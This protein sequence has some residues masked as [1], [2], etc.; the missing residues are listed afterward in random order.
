MIQFK[1]RELCVMSTRKE[2]ENKGF[3][4]DECPPCGLV[5]FRESRMHILIGRNGT[6]HKCRVGW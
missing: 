3:S 1:N 4:K 5:Y 6:L 2:V